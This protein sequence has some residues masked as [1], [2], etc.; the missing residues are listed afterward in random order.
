[1]FKKFNLKEDIATQSQVKSSVQRSIRS[2]IL[3][4]YK[5]L[6]SV[7]EE[8]LPKKAPLVLVKWQALMIH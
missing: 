2:K 7:I 4:Q 8:V 3:E 1:M 6:E 5:K